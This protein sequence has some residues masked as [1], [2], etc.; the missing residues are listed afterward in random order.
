[1]M[2]ETGVR[3]SMSLDV[4]PALNGLVR[5][6]LSCPPSCLKSLVNMTTEPA[7]TKAEWVITAAR[8]FPG[9]KDHPVA[10]PSYQTVT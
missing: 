6:L 5:Y 2:V 7:L 4:K 9:R 1:M 10:R 8:Y 3:R